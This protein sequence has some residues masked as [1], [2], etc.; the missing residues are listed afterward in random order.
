MK[1]VKCSHL[2]QRCKGTIYSML[3]ALYDGA[4]I[5]NNEQRVVMSCWLTYDCNPNQEIRWEVLSENHVSV[6]VPE[7]DDSRL[8]IFDV[9]L[10]VS[11][12]SV[13]SEIDGERVMITGMETKLPCNFVQHLK[14]CACGELTDDPPD[15]SEYAVRDYYWSQINIHANEEY[16]K[17]G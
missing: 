16:N 1:K 9:D 15:D 17:K 4:R 10:M 5:T 6:I 2:C 3:R 7:N 12:V 13:T 11:R 8:V 14:N